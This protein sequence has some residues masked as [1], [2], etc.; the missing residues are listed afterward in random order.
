M[1]NVEFIHYFKIRFD[2]FI[3][4]IAP[5]HTMFISSANNFIIYI[6]KVLNV[7]YFIAKM[8]E[9][10]FNNIPSN[11]WTSIANMRMIVWCYTAYID[12]YL[13]WY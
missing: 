7:F 10:T 6:S 9:V 12:A 3:G 1:L 4:N 5:L 11:E 2:V 13:S 8:T